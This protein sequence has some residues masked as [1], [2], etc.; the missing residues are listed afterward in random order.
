MLR[1]TVE[2]FCLKPEVPDWMDLVYALVALNAW[3]I[4]V[5]SVAPIMQEAAF[6]KGP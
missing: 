4:T 2:L 3:I 5:S 6:L 1:G